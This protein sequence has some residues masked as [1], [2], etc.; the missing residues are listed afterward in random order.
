MRKLVTAGTLAAAGVVA[1]AGTVG[2]VK[3]G[4]PDTEN[5]YPW[6]GLMVAVDDDGEPLWRCTGSLLSRDL[7]LTAGHCVGDPAAA[8][9]DQ[10]ARVYIWFTEGDEVIDTDPVYL[11]NLQEQA[12]NPD[13]DID[14]CEGVEGYPC[15]GYDASGVPVAHPEWSGALT[16]PQTS[17]VGLVT[18]LRW[19]R[20]ADIPD[21]FGVLAPGGY[22]DELAYESGVGNVEFTVVGYGLQS[23]KPVESGI[24]QRRVGTVSLVNLGS[25]LDGRLEHSLFE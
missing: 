19:A 23:V 8:P 11:A 25:A 4:E 15:A 6:V 18:D 24:K 10:P 21:E 14:L 1:A 5:A 17:D 3:F 16:I 12:A 22:L 13:E 2:A 20:G 7:F 9:E